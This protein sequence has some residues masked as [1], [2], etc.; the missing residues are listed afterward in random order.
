[1]LVSYRDYILK[2]IV[3]KQRQGK[4]FCKGQIPNILGF[5]AML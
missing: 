1:M 4:F 3:L 5:V 2:A